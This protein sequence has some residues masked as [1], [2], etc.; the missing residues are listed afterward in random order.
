[1]SNQLAPITKPLNK[2]VNATNK[3]NAAN[4]NLA[5]GVAPTANA[6]KAALNSGIAG[7]NFGTAATNTNAI[8]SRLPPGNSKNA[9]K[10]AANYFQLASIKA[11]QNNGNAAAKHASN[12]IKQ[13]TN[14]LNPNK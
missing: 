1:M 14:A 13:I 12:G 10:K 8:A 4:A 2:A 3:I 6:T 7:S 11:Y 9:L 5:Q